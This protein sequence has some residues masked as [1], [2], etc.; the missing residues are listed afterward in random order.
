MH[1]TSVYLTDEEAESLRRL[2]V[3]ESRVQVERIVPADQ[4][5]DVL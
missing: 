5:G 2:A 4:A 1:M 3:R